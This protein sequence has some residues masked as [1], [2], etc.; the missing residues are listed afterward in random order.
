MHPAHIVAGDYRP[1]YF[2]QLI[3]RTHWSAWG[4]T[5]ALA[6][7]NILSS[8]S[9][10]YGRTSATFEPGPPSSALESGLG[11]AELPV[12]GLQWDPSYGD[13]PTNP[14]AEA[15]LGI[16]MVTTLPDLINPI[17]LLSETA[18]IVV[19]ALDMVMGIAA[20]VATVLSVEAST[21]RGSLPLNAVHPVGRPMLPAPN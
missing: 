20:G 12:L 2:Q 9:F 10:S 18:A 1:E 5:E 11:V 3:D 19:G 16:N 15:A 13:A 21:G 4:I 8:I 6:L 17:K 14:L 7:T